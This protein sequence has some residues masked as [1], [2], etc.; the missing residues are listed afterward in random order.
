[1]IIIR[2][3]RYQC[4][5]SSRYCGMVFFCLCASLS[6]ADQDLAYLDLSLEQLLDVPVTGSTLTEESLKTVPAAVSVFTHEQIERLGVDYLYEL[7]NLVPG[8]QF[9]RNASNG[10]AYTYS[11]RGR[12]GTQQ[13]LEVL[14]LIDGHVVNDPR[15]GSP[16]IT[17]PLYPLARVERLEIIRGPGS[18]IYGS[19]AF[20]GVINIVTRK[21]QRSIALA[22]GSQQRR[23]LEGL[24]SAQMS[25]WALDSFIHAYKDNGDEF[26]LPDSFT[27]QPIV[28]RDPRQQFAVD[29]ALTRAQTH[30]A[31]SYYRTETADFYQTENTAND[32]NASER[33]LWHLA[34]DQG[35]SWLPNTQSKIS[36]SYQ[37]FTYDFDLYLTGPG[38]LAHAS[39]PSSAEPFKGSARLASD[40]WRFTFS[41]DWAINADSSAQWGLQLAR[42]QETDASANANFDLEQLTQKRYPI[43]YYGEPGKVFPLGAETSQ[44]NIGV[45]AQYLRNLRESTR[46]TLGGRYDEYPDIT[47]RFSPRLGVVEQLSDIY[48]VKL[49]YG[50]AFRAPT[51][52]ETGLMNNPLLFGNPELTHEIVKTWDLILMGNWQATSLSLGV[53][54]NRYQ[55]PIE[56]VFSGGARTYENGDKEQSQ[57]LELEWLQELSD[58]WSLRTT[59]TR[60]DLPNSAFR[61]AEQLASME[62]NY[63]VAH[64]NW[65]LMGFYQDQR[66]NPLT[67]TT[68]QTLDDFWVLNS[69]WRYEFAQG[70][71]LS[72]QL[73]NLTN[74]DYA[75]P[76]QS[77]GR[78]GGIPNR[79]RELSVEVEWQF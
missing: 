38:Q 79:G 47:G 60:M 65:N 27:N 45:Y 43:N 36:L 23:Q 49:L 18:A 10:V 1:M 26:G 52:T 35:F 13:S 7:L 78:A 19:S 41:N 21:Q 55:K 22:Y 25:D 58:S 20:N 76:S 51:L 2:S 15:A 57:G 37:Q 75:T 59:Y 33:Q 11:A 6:H 17:L 63:S 74:S 5:H 70:Y 53:F 67:E 72:V 3:M 61:E 71:D 31:L 12:R 68:L 40:S 48:S 30:L 66:Q 16:D 14:L 77:L 32:Y 56:T 29:L 9:N 4:Q 28:T 73:K 46:L 54:Q 50:E 8:F 24:W 42:N 62:I 64:W 69:E 44:D 34:L 39:R